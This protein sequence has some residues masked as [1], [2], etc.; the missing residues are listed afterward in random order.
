MAARR[1]KISVYGAKTRILQRRL[2]FEAFGLSFK[3]AKVYLFLGGVEGEGLYSVSNKI[4][5]ENPTRVYDKESIDVPI[6]M[7]PMPEM[8]T[9]FSRFGG[10][11]ALTD[12]LTFRMHIDDFKLL[13]RELIVGDVFEIPFHE[14]EGFA[15]FEVTDV[16]LRNAMEKYIAIIKAVPLKKSRKT[17]DLNHIINR[18][19]SAIVDIMQEEM[20]E[21]MNDNVP[22]GELTYD[23]DKQPEDIEDDDVDFRKK[24]Q[25]SFLDDPDAK[26]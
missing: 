20:R 25:A 8:K 3:E 1:G 16:D 11:S 22:S 13:G 18:D 23:L 12:E 4:F 14:D 9:D 17:K 21:E 19:N 10:L 24:K 5:S 15:L 6:G 26:F 2:A 7:E